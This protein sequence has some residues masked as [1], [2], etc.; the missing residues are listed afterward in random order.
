MLVLVL[1]YGLGMRGCTEMCW[2]KACLHRLD[3]GLFGLQSFTH[4]DVT[5]HSVEETHYRTN[6]TLDR[7]SLQGIPRVS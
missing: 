5:S 1:I 4:S 7:Y 2:L 3:T 6:S